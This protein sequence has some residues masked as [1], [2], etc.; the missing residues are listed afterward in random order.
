MNTIKLYSDAGHTNQIQLTIPGTDGGDRTVQNA[1]SFVDVTGKTLKVKI[2][3]EALKQNNIHHGDQLWMV[4][5]GAGGLESAV[6]TDPDNPTTSIKNVD[7]AK[8]SQQ[9]TAEFI[10]LKPVNLLVGMSLL[11]SQKT[12]IQHGQMARQRSSC[13][14]RSR[15]T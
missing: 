12:L 11:N 3:P 8:F 6:V 2:N 4:Y 13:W 14:Q 1:L 10:E 5:D 9:F 15:I 7:V